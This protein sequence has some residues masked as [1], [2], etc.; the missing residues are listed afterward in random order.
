MVH[1]LIETLLLDHSARIGLYFVAAMLEISK[2]DINR[3]LF[4]RGTFL[5]EILMWCLPSDTLL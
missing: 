4:W 5:S 2:V 1:F 3:L